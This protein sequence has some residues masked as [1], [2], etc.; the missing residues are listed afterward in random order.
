MSCEEK[1]GER[2]CTTQQQ[3]LFCHLVR[4]GSYQAVAAADSATA[5]GGARPNAF[6]H[7]DRLEVELS[8]LPRLLLHQQDIRQVPASYRQDETNVMD[9]YPNPDGMGELIRFRLRTPYPDLGKPN[10]LQNSK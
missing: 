4:V 6:L 2:S 7:E 8:G 10:I 5:D 3:P 9:T 1:E